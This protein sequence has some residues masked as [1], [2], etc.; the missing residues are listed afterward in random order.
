MIASTESHDAPDLT[1]EEE[2]EAWI[3]LAAVLY[4]MF[5]SVYGP[6]YGKDLMAAEESARVNELTNSS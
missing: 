6:D 5:Q 4:D 1:A 3:R 2:R